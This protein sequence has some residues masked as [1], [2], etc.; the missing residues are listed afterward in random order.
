MIPSPVCIVFIQ[1]FEKCARAVGDG[2]FT[3]YL[4]TPNDKP[5]IGWG[6]TGADINLGMAPWTQAQCDAQFAHDLTQ[7][8][9]GVT[10]AA[11]DVP[12]TQNQFDALVSLA[13]N[14]GLAAFES[15]TLLRL[16]KAG[17]YAGAAA[18]FPKWDHQAGAV[19]DGL[20]VRRE[21]ERAMYLG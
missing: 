13:Y 1:G 10:R 17:D 5:T 11:G 12:V 19:V 8:A 18:E 21:A 20:L 3:A 15:S 9:Q 2:T 4:P 7:F 16:H 6:S 14:I